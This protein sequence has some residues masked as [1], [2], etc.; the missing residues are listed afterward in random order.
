MRAAGASPARW[1]S[2]SWP[3]AC[4]REPPRPVHRHAAD[5]HRHRRR[6]VEGDPPA[7]GRGE[8]AASQGDRRP[9]GGHA[10]CTPPTTPRRSSG[11]PIATGVIPQVHG[12]TDF[13][14]P[15][16]R[17][18]RAGLL[19]RAQ[20]AGAL[21]H[22]DPGRP[23]GGGARLVGLLAG[24]A[25]QRRGAERPRPARTSSAGS[26]RLLPADVPSRTSGRP[27]PSPGLFGPDDEAQRRDRAMARPRPAGPRRRSTC[28]LLY[29]RSPDIVSHNEWKYFEPEAFDPTRSAGAGGPPGPRPAGLR[30][31]GPGDRPASSPPRRRTPT[32]WCSP[33]TASTPRTARSQGAGRH[34]RHPERLGYLRRR[35]RRRHRLLPDPG[36]YLWLA[37]F[38]A[39]QDAP[40]RA[41]RPRAGRAG[42]GRRSARRCAAGWRP[43]SR[44]VTNERGEPVFFLRDARPKRGRRGTSWPSSGCR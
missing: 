7:L 42:S 40:L 19:R 43:T 32:C 13:V 36:L 26:P 35:G 28:I 20:G 18:G 44:R 15:D 12:I 14:V 41:R 17:G 10:P 34:G 38:R 27:T 8:A 25:G 1:P 4:R 6:R 30:G 2:C 5:R 16:R 29:F 31:G 3:G 21:E 24:R 39:G 37:G 22:G 23:A 33:T 9:R 11:P